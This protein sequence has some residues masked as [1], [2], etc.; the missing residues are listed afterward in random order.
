MLS[1]LMAAGLIGQLSSRVGF[2]IKSFE[3]WRRE[4]IGRRSVV[5]IADLGFGVLDS[6]TVEAAAY[7]IENRPAKDDAITV[8]CR[9]LTADQKAEAL[10]ECVFYSLDKRRFIFQIKECDCLPLAPWVYWV[11]RETRKK[12]AAPERL[13]P[14][15]AL[16]RQGL[17]TGDNNRFIRALWEVPP[18][19]I[20]TTP[21]QKIAFNHQSSHGKRWA[22]H[23]RSGSSQPWYSPLTV[24]I[25]WENHGLRLKEH[26]RSRGESPS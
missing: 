7:V 9:L 6:A 5:A 13:E 2:F 12:L 22:P 14:E 20:S 8:V 15:G 3:S 25:D 4:T 11:S 18:S 10:H 19:L 21:D 23:V 17:G 16:V 26:W 1:M 24:L